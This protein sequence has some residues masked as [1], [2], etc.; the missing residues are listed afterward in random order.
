MDNVILD[1]LNKGKKTLRLLLRPLRIT[2]VRD[3]FEYT[4]DK[5]T[6]RYL[7]WGPH[8]EVDQAKQ[9]ISKVLIQYKQPIDI[10]W[11]IDFGNKLI[12]VVRIYNIDLEKKN[13]E[14]SYILNSSFKGNGYMTEAIEGAIQ[15]CF[16]YLGLSDIFAFC[17]HEN[18]PSFNTLIR[19][20][21]E[22]TNES[23][24]QEIKGNNRKILKFKI[25][26]ERTLK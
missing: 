10:V 11:G 8:T 1:V 25:N 6:C 2:D 7:E 15:V 17:D 18:E 19:C 21:M 12:G 23:H 9:F 20:G 4:S 5:Q 13:A 16:D 22:E 14:I 3:M 24:Y 26:K